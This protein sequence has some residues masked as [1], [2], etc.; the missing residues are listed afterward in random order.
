MRYMHGNNNFLIPSRFISE[1]EDGLLESIKTQNSRPIKSYADHK[2]TNHQFD[3]DYS[4]DTNID[5]FSQ[6]DS[7]IYIKVGQRVRHMK[8]GVGVILSYTGKGDSLKLQINFESYGKKWLVMS[9][10]QLDF[11]A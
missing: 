4:Q 11:N 8:F 3:D 7:S 2:K 1:I 9:Y 10:A 5:H 6:E